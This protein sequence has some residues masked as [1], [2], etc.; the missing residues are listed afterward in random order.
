MCF[1]SVSKRQDAP[2]RAA[3]GF[4]TFFWT[5]ATDPPGTSDYFDG[6]SNISSDKGKPVER[7]RRKA[8]GLRPTR[9][10]AA[11]P[12][13]GEVPVG[14]CSPHPLWMQGFFV[15]PTRAEG[16]EGDGETVQSSWSTRMGGSY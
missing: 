2:E 15:P 3:S 7:R 1:E 16:I 11:E 4:Q 10:M 13:K 6:Q 8:T 5:G 9:D 14:V 12:P